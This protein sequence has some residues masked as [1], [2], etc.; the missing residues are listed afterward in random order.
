MGHV[1]REFMK[2]KLSEV[3][4]VMFWLHKSAAIW[5]PSADLYSQNQRVEKSEQTIFSVKIQKVDFGLNSRQTELKMKCSSL[6]RDVSAVAKVVR[7]E[8]VQ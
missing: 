7:I 8:A 4:C 6:D 2:D 5:P 3:F 1:A